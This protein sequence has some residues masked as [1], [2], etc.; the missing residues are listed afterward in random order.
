MNLSQGKQIKESNWLLWILF[1]IHSPISI[2]E[3]DLNGVD[4]SYWTHK[5]VL[6]F[7]MKHLP[8]LNS[9]SPAGD[10]VFWSDA[11]CKRWAQ[12]EE[13]SHWGVTLKVTPV[14]LSLPFPSSCSPSPWYP[15]CGLK[16]LKLCASSIKFY[17]TVIKSWLI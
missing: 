4:C 11:N 1:F 2:K 16:P 13:V 8:W 7:G 12:P 9:W 5:S 10:G 15:S 6:W 17:V 14:H 3:K